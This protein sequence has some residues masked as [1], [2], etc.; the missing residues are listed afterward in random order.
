MSNFEDNISFL[1]QSPVFSMSLGSKELFH[2][3]FWAWIIEQEEGRP[4]INVFFP[5]FK[6]SDFKEVKREDGNRDLVIRDVAGNEYVIENKIKS[7]P[8]LKQIEDYRCFKGVLTGIKEPPFELPKKW[9]FKSYKTIG[10]KLQSIARCFPEGFNRK[11]IEEYSKVVLAIDEIINES[12][13]ERKE[14]LSF[15]TSKTSDLQSIRMLD[16]YKKAKADDFAVRC[17]DLIKDIKPLIEKT[18]WDCWISRSFHNGKATIS[19]DI[20]KGS[21]KDY[22]GMIGVQIEDNQFRLFLGVSKEKGMHAKEIFDQGI[23]M[24]WFD[25]TFDKKTNRTVFGHPTKMSKTP[26]SYSDRWVYQYFDTWTEECDLQQYDLLKSLID[27]WLKKA[28]EIINN[29]PIADVIFN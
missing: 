13:N 20:Q 11:I 1:K 29:D 8:S 14:Y 23:K 12:L 25:S 4:F 3:N 10:E 16:V 15:E 18:G 17:E 28:V 22:K 21:E 2:S 27:K 26:C 9:E 6:L 7:Y 19:F 5:D 24:G